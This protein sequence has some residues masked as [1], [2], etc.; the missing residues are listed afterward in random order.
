MWGK[1]RA[2]K[3][4]LASRNRYTSSCLSLSL[5]ARA[6]EPVRSVRQGSPQYVT[7]A[8]TQSF[9]HSHWN[10]ACQCHS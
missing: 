4:N 3:H 8:S 9:V 5:F 2:K 7:I 1:S 10:L 6:L